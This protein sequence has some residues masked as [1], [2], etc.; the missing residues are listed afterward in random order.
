M[1]LIGLGPRSSL[2]ACWSGKKVGRRDMIQ[3][4]GATKPLFRLK[5]ARSIG[6]MKR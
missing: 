1:L 4:E 2:D 5:H 3:A 6:E